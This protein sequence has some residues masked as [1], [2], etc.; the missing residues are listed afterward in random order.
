MAGKPFNC[1]KCGVPGEYEP[2]MMNG[3]EFTIRRYCFACSAELEAEYVR[4]EMNER[5]QE[6]E[7]KWAEV[8]PPIYRETDPSRISQELVRASAGWDE[9]SSLGLGFLGSTGIGKTRALFL[10]LRKAFDAG[11]ST[12]SVSHNAFSRIVQD[13]FAGDD[14]SRAEAK[15]RLKSLHNCAVLLIDDLGKSPATERADAELEELIEVRTC[16]KRPTL[17]SA[18]GSSEWLSRRLGPDR[19]EPLVRRLSEFSKVVSL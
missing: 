5:Q 7:A 10:A 6:R 4:K 17:W 14:R 16:H 15:T 2:M 1:E 12:Q 9:S 3:R 13:A 18:N 11:K 8:C 19:G